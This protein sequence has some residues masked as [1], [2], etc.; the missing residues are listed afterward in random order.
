MG[1][2]FPIGYSRSPLP[3]M[4]HGMRWV[5]GSLSP[6]GHRTIE[7]AGWEK[8]F[9]IKSSPHPSTAQGHH[10]DM[11]GPKCPMGCSGSLTPHTCRVPRHPW[12]CWLLSIPLCRRTGLIPCENPQLAQLSKEMVTPLVNQWPSLGTLNGNESGSDSKLYR[13]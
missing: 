10:L 11:E 8:T 12:E 5:V 7:S 4:P 9:K 1:G 3:H 13:R 2:R 6:V